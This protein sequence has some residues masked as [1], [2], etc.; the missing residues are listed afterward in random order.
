MVDNIGGNQPQQHDRPEYERMAAVTG[1][2]RVRL[3]VGHVDADSAYVVEDYPY[4]GALRCRIRYWI[5]TA[6]ST[7]SND[8]SG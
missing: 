1:I 7:A 4:G 5:D 3:L 6:F 2:P 8:A